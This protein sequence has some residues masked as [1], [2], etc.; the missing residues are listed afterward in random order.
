MQMLRASGMP[1]R[2]RAATGLVIAGL[3]M[4]GPALAGSIDTMPLTPGPG[5]GVRSGAGPAV[6]AVLRPISVRAELTRAEKPAPR[7]PKRTV[8]A[9]TRPSEPPSAPPPTVLL[10][11]PATTLHAFYACAT[12]PLPAKP[13][14][15]AVGPQR[16]A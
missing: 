13:G 1:W 16:R 8:P 9:R 14:W 3:G 2:R 10:E 15:L 12:L 7:R 11:P 4:S 5:C 6:P